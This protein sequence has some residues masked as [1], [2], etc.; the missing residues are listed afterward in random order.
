MPNILLLALVLYCLIKKQENI[1]IWNFYYNPNCWMCLYLAISETKYLRAELQRMPPLK[2]KCF[3]FL[4]ILHVVGIFSILNLT[5]S[6]FQ[7]PS[8]LVAFRCSHETQPPSALL[9]Q[10]LLVLR[11]HLAFLQLPAQHQK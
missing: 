6:R 5:C 3:V 9:P 4:L 7:T 11:L 1:L 10:N 2:K 8:F